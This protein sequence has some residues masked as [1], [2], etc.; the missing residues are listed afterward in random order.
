[1]QDNQNLDKAFWESRYQEGQ[2]GWDIGNP[3]TPLTSYALS[4]ASVDD[5]ILIPGAGRG[6]ELEF[7]WNNGYTQCTALDLAIQA[8]E[9]FRKR[10]PD[11][12]E[13]QYVLEDFF[14][15]KG[16]YDLVLEQ[17]FFCAID[18][19]LRKQY[20]EK[21]ASL[22]SPKGRMAGVLFDF[23]LDAGPP[24]GGSKEEYLTLFQKYF[25]VRKMEPCRNSIAPRAGRELFV[26]FVKR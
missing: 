21:L 12:P 13:N 26:E 19:Q 9:A 18:P 11:I 20:V 22:L 15:H 8:K 2:T 16:V 3:S 14:E 23:P 1:M 17:T 7:L 10:C 25:S 5:R 6:Y 4:S 24:F